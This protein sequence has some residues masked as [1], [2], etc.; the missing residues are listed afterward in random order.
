MT[1]EHNFSVFW[2]REYPNF[3]LPG[4]ET[5]KYN[6]YLTSNFE[7]GCSKSPPTGRY[8]QY[9]T[10]QKNSELTGFMIL[11][12]IMVKEATF[13]SRSNTV[14]VFDNGNTRVAMRI[15]IKHNNWSDTLLLSLS[16]TPWW[17]RPYTTSIKWDRRVKRIVYVKN[18]TVFKHD[19]LWRQ[20]TK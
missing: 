6:L 12:W 13:N 18:T 7:H 5:R 11:R 2:Y 15:Y 8:Q 10:I 1:S 3:C 19:Y 16:S 4:C 9:V 14:K 20:K 17:R